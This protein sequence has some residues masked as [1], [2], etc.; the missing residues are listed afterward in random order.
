MAYFAGKV[1]ILLHLGLGGRVVPGF[2]GRLTG[3]QAPDPGGPVIYFYQVDGISRS[4]WRRG[5]EYGA[6]ELSVLHSPV[7]PWLRVTSTRP[8][9]PSAGAFWADSDFWLRLLLGTAGMAVGL[10]VERLW[11]RFER[12]G[13]HFLAGLERQEHP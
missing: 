8:G 9:L 11:A 12:R 1:L 4:G 2:S 6:Q 7:L 13:G 10:G 5:I 3:D